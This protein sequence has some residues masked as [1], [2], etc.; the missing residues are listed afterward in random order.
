MDPAA[1]HPIIHSGAANASEGH[2]EMNG[3]KVRFF[4]AVLAKEAGRYEGSQSA[5]E[6]P[7]RATCVQGAAE[8]QRRG[9]GGSQ[10]T[11]NLITDKL[12]LP[13]CTPNRISCQVLNALFPEV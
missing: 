6:L 7:I 5:S 1:V 13:C 2:G 8:Q 11:A 10:R 9:R 3:Q 12:Y 4:L